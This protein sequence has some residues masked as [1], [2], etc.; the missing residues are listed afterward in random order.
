[1]IALKLYLVFDRE[2][3]FLFKIVAESAPEALRE[4]RTLKARA[5]T[6]YL[7]TKGNAHESA[8]ILTYEPHLTRV[9]DAFPESAMDHQPSTINH[10]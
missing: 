8:A 2:G 6:A 1:M 5:C 3:E 4:A 10:S 7:K 9:A